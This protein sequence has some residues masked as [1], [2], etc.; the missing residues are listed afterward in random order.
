MSKGG[1]KRNAALKKLSK[2]SS[3][4]DGG[5]GGSSAPSY[6]PEQFAEFKRQTKTDDATA[7]LH[8]EA[9]AKKLHAERAHSIVRSE[10]PAA[11]PEAAPAERS[12][13]PPV[14]SAVPGAAAGTLTP[15]ARIIKSEHVPTDTLDEKRAPAPARAAAAAAPSVDSSRHADNQNVAGRLYAARALGGD[16]EEKPNAAIEKLKAT[17][18]AVAG[19]IPG[20]GKLKAFAGKFTGAGHA[21]AMQAAG[22]KHESEAETHARATYHLAAN[23]LNQALKA[24]PTGHDA[25]KLAMAHRDVARA[26]QGVSKYLSP[27][28][29]DRLKAVAEKHNAHAD[30][31]KAA[32]GKD[33]AAMSAA[34]KHAD[35]A[36]NS[37]PPGT[38]AP[39]GQGWTEDLHP[40]DGGKF[41]NK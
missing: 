28:A 10:A 33:K 24:D 26:A 15:R 2:A 5:G 27:D 31:H 25:T 34:F 14:G 35:N 18:G 21:A 7:H 41:T 8:L 20:A 23:A 3:E 30:A 6:T 17:A 12:D 37:P 36:R 39:G 29:K 9:A 1:K 4:G 32:V 40:R 11:A 16:P 22:A 13:S 19:K 38:P